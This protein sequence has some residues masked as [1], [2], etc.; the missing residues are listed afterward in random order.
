M[1]VQIIIKIVIKGESIGSQAIEAILYAIV[2]ARL[3]TDGRT[4]K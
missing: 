1:Q 2:V 3:D 4:F